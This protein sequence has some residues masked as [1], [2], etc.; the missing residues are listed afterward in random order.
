[1]LQ[2]QN[3]LKLTV[4]QEANAVKMAE[5]DR[6]GGAVA[7]ALGHLALWKK[8][9]QFPG[10]TVILED[11]ATL[12]NGW[13]A[14]T[15]RD[16][17]LSTAVGQLLWLE[18]RSCPRLRDPGPGAALYVAGGGYGTVAYAVT[19]HTA[20]RLY[21]LFDFSQP[22]DLW[23]QRH[24]MGSC[25]VGFDHVYGLSLLPFRHTGENDEN[26]EIHNSTK[27]GIELIHTRKPAR[28]S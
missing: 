27:T 2:K 26:S 21:K 14:S 25:E 17:L 20:S 13:N 12:Q 6:G 7:C 1:M 5:K 11:D 23:M 28:R 24:G 8:A 16:G 15:L 18:P 3:L 10:W 22:V 19:A 4:E 9:S